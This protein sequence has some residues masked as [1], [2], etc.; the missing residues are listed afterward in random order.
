M[1]GGELL[2]LW[3]WW[4]LVVLRYAL[5]V[6]WGWEARKGGQTVSH[7]FI[8]VEIRMVLGTWVLVLGGAGVGCNL[9]LCVGERADCATVS[10]DLARSFAMA[11]NVPLQ[12]PSRSYPMLV[13]FLLSSSS[14]SSS[15][16]S[17]G[18]GTDSRPPP[19]G[20]RGEPGAYSREPAAA[21]WRGRGDGGG[22]EGGEGDSQGGGGDGGDGGG[23]GKPGLCMNP[24]I[25]F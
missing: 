18:K 6:G 16:S 2:W 17:P 4:W 7:D 21:G 25:L 14:S 1:V 3:C 19:Q 11:R 10:H 13:R 9:D 5:T 23:E 22:G 24:H 8:F 12:P 15:S 20:S